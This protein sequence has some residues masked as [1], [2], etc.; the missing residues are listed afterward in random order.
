MRH[1]VICEFVAIPS[2]TDIDESAQHSR[3][4]HLIRALEA[5]HARESKTAPETPSPAS[6]GRVSWERHAASRTQA[7]TLVHISEAAPARVTPAQPC[8]QPLRQGPPQV[9]QAPARVHPAVARPIQ[10]L[11]PARNRLQGI[12]LAGRAS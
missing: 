3:P 10:V 12:L 4:A 8:R 1:G 5:R 2:E 7:A 6:L 11:V 9:L